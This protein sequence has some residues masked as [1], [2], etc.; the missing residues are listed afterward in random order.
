[1]S[2]NSFIIF[3][4]KENPTFP[5]NFDKRNFTKGA[6]KCKVAVLKFIISGRC[7][8]RTQVSTNFTTTS[9]L[10]NY[11]TFL[12]VGLCVCNMFVVISIHILGHTVWWL[13]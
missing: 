2:E 11:T 5:G 9:V 4:A 6:V 13:D 12:E 10:E 3:H 1:M 7:Y 8:F